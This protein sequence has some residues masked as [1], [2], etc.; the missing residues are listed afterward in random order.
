[1]SKKEDAAAPAQPVED[2]FPLT[3]DE[4]CSQQSKSDKRVALIG[5]FHATEKAGGRVKDT[6]A[7]FQARYEQFIKQPA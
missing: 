5:G 3:L 2:S 7:A 6:A 4:F 1:M